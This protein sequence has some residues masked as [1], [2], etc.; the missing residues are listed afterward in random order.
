M[1]QY[2]SVPGTG[3][4]LDAELEHVKSYIEK[5]IQE[6]CHT[7]GK[8]HLNWHLSHDALSCWLLLAVH[9]ARRRTELCNASPI[10]HRR[11]QE[12]QRLL[13]GLCT[14][15][16]M[17][18]LKTPG[19]VRMTHR[20]GIFPFAA[21]ILLRLGGQRDLVLRTA[22]HMSGEPG[23]PHVPTFVRQSGT[24]M[25]VM[26]WF[27]RSRFLQGASFTK[28]LFSKTHFSRAPTPLPQAHVGPDHDRPHLVEEEL[29][30]GRSQDSQVHAP[31]LSNGDIHGLQTT[32]GG[33]FPSFNLPEFPYVPN[34]DLPQIQ[35][36]ESLLLPASPLG[37]L[38]QWGLSEIENWIGTTT[39]SQPL[40]DSENSA[41]MQVTSIGLPFDPMASCRVPLGE[42]HTEVTWNRDDLSPA[43]TFPAAPGVSTTRENT[44][45]EQREDLLSAVDHLKQLVSLIQ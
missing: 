5:W 11:K 7:E 15:L 9:I 12:Q 44:S 38:G 8:P 28:M 24:Q 3:L 43:N 23:K 4:S 10:S 36:Q 42:P 35:V 45:N 26:L 17:G 41:P 32:E 6:W 30:A 14:R 18:S 20:A 16:F 27:V 34:P 31:I 21:S 37:D 33:V 40:Q 2:Q 13:L 22:L 29:E 19:A 1:E 39:S 25:L